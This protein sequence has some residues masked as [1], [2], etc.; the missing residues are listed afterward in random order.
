[1]AGTILIVEDDDDERDVMVFQLEQ[2]GFEVRACRD[3]TE[4]LGAVDA[5]LSAMVIK[6][7][8]PGL[9]GP[10]LCRQMRANPGVADVPIL[11]VSLSAVGD[12]DEV[13]AAF[14]AGADDWLIEPVHIREFLARLDALLARCKRHPDHFRQPVHHI[15]SRE[16]AARAAA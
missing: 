10:D 4:A 14:D 8:L 6:E 2:H 1:V 13:V 11:M 5:G 9:G 15:Q 3:A 12:E 16:P 7:R